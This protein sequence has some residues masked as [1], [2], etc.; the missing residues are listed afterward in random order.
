MACGCAKRR[1]KLKAWAKKQA[2]K[3]LRRGKDGK[4]TATDQQPEASG[5]D[6]Q[7]EQPEPSSGSR[8]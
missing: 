6:G 5:A 3:V 8:A 7:P 4:D 1:A 2:D